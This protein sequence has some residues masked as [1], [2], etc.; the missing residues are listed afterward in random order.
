MR[1]IQLLAIFVLPFLL[2]GGYFMYLKYRAQQLGSDAPRWEDGPWFWLALAGAV[3]VIAA[4]V[5]LDAFDVSA[6]Q[7]IVTP[8]TLRD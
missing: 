1:L 3:L 7:R 5:A 4:I 2:Y 8:P 6:P